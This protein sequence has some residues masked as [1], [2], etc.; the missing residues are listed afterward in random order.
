MRHIYLV[1]SLLFIFQ[2]TFAQKVKIS[3]TV[4]DEG[5]KT[6][7]EYATVVLYRSADSTYMTG[8]L[9]DSIGSFTI[10]APRGDYFLEVNHINYQRFYHKI[11]VV[12]ADTTLHSLSIPLNILNLK[13]V[14]VLGYSPAV[15]FTDKA[16]VYKVSDIPA[17]GTGSFTDLF[18]NIPSLTFDF[19]EAVLIN[20]T[21][22]RFFIDGREIT[23]NELKAY[24][25][26]QI[27]TIEVMSNPTAQY[28][29]NGLSGIVQLHSK[30]TTLTGIGGA[31]NISGAHD[32]QTG[33]TNISYN[34]KKLS[35][36]SAFSIWNNHQHGYIETQASN[37]TTRN[38][39]LATIMNINANAS[40]DYHLN[41]RNMLSASYQ[42]INFG[43]TSKDYSAKRMG[44]SD[45]RGITHQFV[46]GYNHQFSRYGETFKASFYYNETS[47]QTISRLN[48]TDEQFNVDNL[49][50]NNSFVA[51]ADYSLPFTENA[52]FEAG[53]KSH[54]RQISIHRT[55]DFSG[56]PSYDKFEMR[57]SILATYV[58][59][60][61]RM[62]K[63]NVQFG[64]RSETNL[65]DRAD[66]S[67]KWD[68]FPNISL[69]YAVNENNI[70]Q[71]GYTNRVN[72]PSAAD[73]NPF[74]LL[75]DPTSTFKGNPELKPEYSHTIF[76]DYTNRYKGND[77]KLS[78]YYRVVNNL[79]TKTFTNTSDGILYTP[80]NI[81][82]AHFYGIDLSSVQNCGKILSIQ[83][84]AGLSSVYIPRGTDKE[85]KN[86]HSFNLGL[87]I[88]VKLPYNFN[89]QA[90][91][92]YYSGALSVGT[93]SQSAIVQGLA[94]GLPQLIT[95]LSASKSLLK[96]NMT[97]SLRVTDPFKLQR[98]GFKVYSD[99]S[100][101]ESIYQMETRFVYLS[102]SYRFNNFKNS[103]RK[104]DDGGIKV[105]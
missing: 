91:G 56:I 7:I 37:A 54:T 101:R 64:L 102:L 46:V 32:I 53:V 96:N 62:E 79:I 98:N 50:H 95:E 28:D 68:I 20:G 41:D 69:D 93:S 59:M 73:L 84:S 45:M 61:S 14:E 25:P 71:L 30:H 85:F 75:I 5:T 27:A 78:A 3:G 97:L 51:M 104:F 60:N 33:S 42:Y 11:G 16:V 1:I 94:I 2:I 65:A 80:V 66:G 24:S 31:A 72:R 63:F 70:L 9:S 12:L 92:R 81:P 87:N 55:D 76:I 8:S 26:S 40:A 99:N 86:I 10:Q 74:V 83:P 19:N 23:T 52:H 21:P 4:V 22:A 105:F 35:F 17:S 47:P 15:R 57:E 90:L 82:T 77:I 34:H 6:G 88:G 38:D 103:A 48:Y 39:V 29:A 44:K 67:R 89:I 36:N 13:E 100:L 58:Q 43:Y 18:K 49:N